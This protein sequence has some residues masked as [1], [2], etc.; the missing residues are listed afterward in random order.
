MQRWRAQIEK[1]LEAVE[2]MAGC[3][4]GR[5]RLVE[6]TGFWLYEWGLLRE[7]CENCGKVVR[8]FD[9]KEAFLREKLR[10]KREDAEALR[11]QL[12]E[13][14]KQEAQEASDADQD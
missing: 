9:K 13:I 7:I 2:K 10:R 8:V 6:P 5:T 11:K 3:R 1:R 14:T 4:H 12:D